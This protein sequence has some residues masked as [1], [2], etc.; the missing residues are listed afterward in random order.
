MLIEGDFINFFI[1]LLTFV[2]IYLYFQAFFRIKPM[3]CEIEIVKTIIYIF[4]NI[5]IISGY[6]CTNDKN[7]C[8]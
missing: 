5:E 2:S 6:I 4:L 7:H 3:T 1:G 8:Q